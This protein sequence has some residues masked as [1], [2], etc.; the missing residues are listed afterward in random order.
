[1]NMRGIA[2]GT[3]TV[4]KLN[5]RP[6]AV[7]APTPAAATPAPAA[8]PVPAPPIPGLPIAPPGTTPTVTTPA[9]TTPPATAPPAQLGRTPVA[10]SFSPARA[11]GQLGSAITVTMQVE[12]AND[13][14]TA[15]FKI[16][17]DPKIIRLND[18]TAGNLLTSDG[19]QILPLSKNIRNDTG[20][21]SDALTRVPGAGG[22]SG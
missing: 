12:N 18:V 11:E 10:V 17:F 3:D 19:K 6:K 16:N 22:V 9:A 20:E 1:T 2:S 5:Y 7:T 8:T 21:A 15:P 14:F 4:V 13:L